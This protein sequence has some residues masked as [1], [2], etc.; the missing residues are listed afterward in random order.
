MHVVIVGAG[1]AGLAVAATLRRRGVDCVVLERA[2]DVGSSWQNRYDSLRL[3][4]A[5]WLSGL[6]GSP[7]PRA[8]GKWVR[9]D[10]LVDYLRSYA[11]R[12]DISIEFEVTVKRIDRTESGWRIST[13]VGQRDAEA[14]VV[15]T[16]YSREPL[17]PSWSGLNEFDRPLIHS[18][19]YREPWGYADKHVLVVG[20]GNS[21]AEI[22]CDL[23][24][25]AARVSLAVRTPPNIVRRDILGVPSQLLGVLLRHVPESLMNPLT[26]WLRRVSIPDLSQFGLSAP[27]K[28]GY[29]QFLRTRTVPILDHGF[30]SMVKDRRIE[31]VAAVDHLSSDTV[32]LEDGTELQPDVVISAT[33]FRP[34]LDEMVGHLGVLDAGGTPLVHG[35]HTLPGAPDLYFVG[36]TVLLAGLLREIGRE[37]RAVGRAIAATG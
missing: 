31:I 19:N 25:A 30:V 15:A 1:A 21:G 8:A 18:T 20:A 9:R 23:V 7:I 17:L 22:A 35:A 24:P 12:H 10:D 37:A 5:R 2:G 28:Q 33:G 34:A 4:T 6:P 11:R 27:S 36:V 32:N 13:S 16:G 3:H 26:R 29:T 14:V